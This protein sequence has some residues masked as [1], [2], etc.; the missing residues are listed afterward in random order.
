MF[1]SALDHFIEF[2]QNESR[3]GSGVTAVINPGTTFTLTNSANQSTGGADNLTGTANDDTFLAVSDQ[4]LDNGD[5]IDGGAGTDTITARYSVDADTTINTSLTN[6]E[7]LVIDTD[8]GDSG[9]PHELNMAVAF[10][11]LEEVRIKDAV[12][13]DGAGVDD[14]NITNIALG[15]NVAV[16][17]GDGIFDVDFQYAGATEQQ[18]PQH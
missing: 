13:T 15:V 17:N 4:A 10:T 16:E 11:G 12:A 8:E 5:V 2:G 1:S 9:N 6:V 3:S 14:I 18:T 7:K